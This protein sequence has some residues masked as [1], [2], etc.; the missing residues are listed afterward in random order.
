MDGLLTIGQLAAAAQVSADTI[1]YYEAVGLLPP[2]RRRAAGYRLYP[3]S[4]VRRLHLVKQGKFL[5]LSLPAVKELVDQTFT[6]SC[7]HL[8]E[9]L[10]ARIPAQLADVEA[11]IDQLQALR[12]DL[13]A[14]QKHLQR[15]DGTLPADPVVE[16]EH[17]PCVAGVERS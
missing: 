17:C 15:L 14:L 13:L 9:T 11:R 7:A 2:P 6:D 1:R 16:C 10:L 5:G 8:Q 4:E 3:P 12:R